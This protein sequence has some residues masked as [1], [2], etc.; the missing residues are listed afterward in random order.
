MADK[1]FLFVGGT[2]R[3]GT[4]AMATMLRAHPAI[5]MGRERY[6]WL[7]RDGGPFVPALFEKERFCREYRP[8]DSHHLKH[9]EYYGELYPRF[10]ACVYVG[11]KL[12]SLYQRYQYVLD[13]FPGCRIIYTARN[14]V[15]VAASFQERARKTAK[16]L[17]AT[18]DADVSRLWS[19]NRNWRAAIGEWNEAVESTLALGDTPRLF[20]ADYEQMFVD[21][22]ML[23]RLAAFLELPVVPELLQHWEQAKRRR[24][25]IEQNRKPGLAPGQ[26]AQIRREAKLDQ[27]N[28]L[29]RR[30]L[31]AQ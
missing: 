2:A 12:P 20:V 8:D 4:S 6:A 27:F 14:P 23:Q 29:L 9:H 7:F 13:T 18:P 28:L 16:Q 25:Q 1:K 21:D 24:G 11:D 26:I 19:V 31:H 30:T 15:D 10:D 5:A 22:S 3:S 17:R